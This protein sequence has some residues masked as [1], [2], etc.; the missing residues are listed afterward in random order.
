MIADDRQVDGTAR[1]LILSGVDRSVIE[2]VLAITQWHGLPADLRVQRIADREQRVADLLGFQTLN[3]RPPQQPVLRVDQLGLGFGN[4]RLGIRGHLI[5]TRIQHQA[6]HLLD[7]PTLFDESPCQPVQQ[8]GM[9]RLAAERAEVLRRADEAGSKMPAPQA[10]DHHPRGERMLAAGHPPRELQSSAL[11]RGQ[12]GLRRRSAQDFRK[13][14]LDTRAERQVTATNVDRQCLGDDA[15]LHAHQR[16]R[17]GRLVFERLQLALH[18]VRSRQH[19]G[20]ERMPILFRDGKKASHVI[21]RVMHGRELH[22][23]GLRRLRVFR[24]S[25][26]Q[27]G[28]GIGKELGVMLANG[29][30]TSGVSRTVNQ[31]ADPHCSLLG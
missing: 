27:C 1:G 8:F 16:G 21:E 29:R 28:G 19:L 9:R 7:A 2:D 26:L 22:I 6:V 30:Q 5:D 10:V 4:W 12:N 13:A 31:R 23:G 25:F 3:V 15:V 20:I 18:H 17:F 11:L 14:A 24:L